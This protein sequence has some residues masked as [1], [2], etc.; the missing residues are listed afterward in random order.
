M[1]GPDDAFL[2][3]LAAIVR[4][5]AGPTLAKSGKLSDK[6]RAWSALRRR[7]GLPKGAR[8][9]LASLR[10]AEAHPRLAAAHDPVLVLW[11]IGTHHG[12]GRPFFRAPERDWPGE[13]AIFE[14]D[15]G[16]GKVSARP[17]RSLAELTALW[18]DMFVGLR[19]RYGPWGL[20]RLEAILRLADHRRS[21]AE[22]EGGAA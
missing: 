14:A 9:E 1:F 7:S 6:P 15:L 10:F 20:A 11:L 16:D 5:V 21:E 18:V 22:Q 4:S 12:Y 8:H 17:A 2:N 3:T 19:R 13:G